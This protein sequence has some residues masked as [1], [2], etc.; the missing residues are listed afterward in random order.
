MALLFLIYAHDFI[1]GIVLKEFLALKGFFIKHKWMYIFGLLAILLTDVLQVFIPKI[2]GQFTDDVQQG[3]FSA[4]WSYVSL[5]LLIAVGMFVFRYL[6]RRLI[7]GAAR[8]LEYQ[9]RSDLFAHYQS[10]STSFF[11]NVKTGDLMAHATND[12][13]A[14]RFAAAAGIVM[15]VDT[16]VLITFTIFMMVQTIS[17]KL[18]VVALLPLPALAFVAFGIGK[19]IHVRFRRSQESFSLLT[20]RVQEN[21]SGMRVVK[22]F[23]QENAEVD[24]FQ[25]TND[26]N[27]QR[28][29]RVAQIQAL[30]HP[31][32]Q[33]ISGISLILV[34]GYGGILVL[35]REITLGDFVAFN[36][37]L[38]LL[39]WPML[40][41]GWMIN[42]FQRGS[43]SMARI[44]VLFANKGEIFDDP[45]KVKPIESIKGDIH[46]NSLS[47]RYPG[48]THNTL[49]NI[50]LHIPVGSSLAIVGRTGSGK[51]TLAN[52][53][54]RLYNV[55]PGS[56]TVDG[57]PIDEIP[58]NVLRS[59]VGY[60]PQD[61][62]LFSATIKENIGFGLDEY[63]QDQ[64]NQAAEDAQLLG[65]VLDFPRQM[66]TMLGERGVTL[67]G[68]QKQR[69]SI[70][71][72]LIKNPSVLILDDSLSAVDTRTEEAILERLK[73]LMQNRT[74]ILISHR[75]STIEHANQIIVLDEG[76]IVE[77]GSHESLL[78]DNGLYRQM[79]EKQLL[80]EKIANEA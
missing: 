60:V 22:A 74:T 7:F 33:L 18:T 24:K 13:T 45:S 79:Y 16:V 26:L 10:L 44:N 21:I 37:Y 34:L 55:E 75:I 71:R 29:M 35:Q 17:W 12:L 2:V 63:S 69:L 30:F 32:V 6:W 77:R 5:I 58:L 68:G 73:D 72:A 47:F 57:R 54:V 78:A 61:N 39:T 27:Y 9:I 62:F 65:N 51:T 76:C 49:S 41:L 19:I 28:N 23:V 11:N 14:I 1:G 3:L 66:E 48:A 43:A 56:L 52:L 4:V 40:A 67:S 25:E 46:F 15:L 8:K 36:F 59:N 50:E 53:L 20:D 38:G 64:V 70:A 31:I 80:E 42:I